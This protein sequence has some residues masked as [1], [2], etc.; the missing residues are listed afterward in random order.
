MVNNIKEQD[1]LNLQAQEDE[2]CTI[3]AIY[4]DDYSRVK[5][6]S[7]AWNVSLLLVLLFLLERVSNSHL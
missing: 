2:L 3:E 1:R 5:S 7:T 4:G 6:S